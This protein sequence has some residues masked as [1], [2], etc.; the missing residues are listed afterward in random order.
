M[1]RHPSRLDISRHVPGV[2]GWFP[3]EDPI[4]GSFRADG[5]QDRWQSACVR[6]VNQNSREG[7]VTT[8]TNYDDWT[9]DRWKADA[10]FPSLE[11]DESA[12]LDQAPPLWKDLTLASLVALG[13]WVVAAMIL[14]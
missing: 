2:T 10:K 1:V 3:G 4:T 8:R 5:L 6:C 9:I 14:R 11:L 7:A 12:P 13:L